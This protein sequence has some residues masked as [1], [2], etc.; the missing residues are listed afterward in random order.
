MF[1]CPW[2][3]TSGK[4][5]SALHCSEGNKFASAQ[6]TEC[7]SSGL[8]ASQV[9]FYAE[10][11]LKI[12]H[13]SDTRT[14][15]SVSAEI[16]SL[17]TAA[18]L[19]MAARSCPPAQCRQPVNGLCM[20]SLESFQRTGDLYLSLSSHTSVMALLSD[21]GVPKLEHW[22]T[23]TGS[24]G[25]QWIKT[26]QRHMAH[27]YLLFSSVLDKNPDLSELPNSQGAGKAAGRYFYVWQF[28]LFNDQVPPSPT[29]TPWHPCQQFHHGALR[30]FLPCAIGECLWI[31]E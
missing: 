29:T 13:I 11:A 20:Q 31:C 12:C 16:S 23:A 10:W 15:P 18:V 14:C 5:F 4:V 6:F 26:V 19:P 9:P 8:K 24:S 3:S 17:C 7:H 30:M 1:T 27:E 28:A 25:A 21:P 2:K 22:I